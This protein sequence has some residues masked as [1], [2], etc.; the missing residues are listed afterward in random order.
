[1]PDG[2]TSTRDR[3]LDAA[4]AL[5]AERGLA[6]TA[7][8]DIATRVELNPASLYNHFASKEALYEAVLERGL[9]PLLEVLAGAAQHEQLVGRVELIDAVMAHLERTPH[10]PR[11]IHHEA[12]TGGTH[13]ARVARVFIRPLVAQALSMLKRHPGIGSGE[14]GWAED[15]HPLLIATWLHLIFGHFAMAPLLSEVFDE[16]ALSSESLARQ[17]RF[18]RKLSL[19]LLDPGDSDKGEPPH[20]AD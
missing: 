9:R 8:R 7:V 10:L 14:S 18:L 15:E 1:L 6:G 2:S 11:L 19:R 4:E 3:I 20:A 5:F 17:T 13:L 12:V 16:D